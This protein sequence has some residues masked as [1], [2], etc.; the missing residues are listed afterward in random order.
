MKKLLSLICIAGMI[1]FGFNEAQAQDTRFGLKGGLTMYSMETSVMGFSET[2]DNKLG[3][4]GGLFVEKPFSDMFSLQFEA[5]FV[6][7]GGEDSDE[8][9][10]DESLTLS[11]VDIP[12]LLKVNIPLDGDTTPYVYGGGFFGYLIDASEEANG[13]T[14]DIGEFFND[15]NYGVAFGAGV[16]FGMFNLDVRYDMGLANIVDEDDEFGDIFGDGGF[17]VNTKGFMV[18]AGIT[19]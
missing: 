10:G 17:E 9:W 16:S 2:S 15:F 6:Q 4:T 13:E 1:A 12:V 3:F 7:K 18:T 8:V 14:H 11:Y 5:L 19:F